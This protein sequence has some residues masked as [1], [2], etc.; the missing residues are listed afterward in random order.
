MALFVLALFVFS[1]P[2]FAQEDTE[3]TSDPS[4]VQHGKDVSIVATTKD[5]VEN[6]NDKFK[7]SRDALRSKQAEVMAAKD[8]TTPENQEIVREY[9]QHQAEYLK[10]VRDRISA[11][12]ELLKYMA[13]NYIEDSEDRA[14]VV[15]HIKDKE[16]QLKEIYVN[17]DDVDTLQEAK[18]LRDKLVAWYKPVRDAIKE[19]RAETQRAKLHSINVKLVNLNAKVQHMIDLLESKSINLGTEYP[20]KVAQLNEALAS[21]QSN[22]DLARS[23]YRQITDTTSDT[24]KAALV[25]QAQNYVDKV[26]EDLKNAKNHLHDLIQTIRTRAGNQEFAQAVAQA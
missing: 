10:A 21:A 26:R 17:I 18:Q 4:R 1:I 24:D 13:E 2:V 7:E 22:L 19:W 5:K 20:A 15:N 23:T 3:D 9:A 12:F 8:S 14:Q 11:N 25:A 6:A 16:D